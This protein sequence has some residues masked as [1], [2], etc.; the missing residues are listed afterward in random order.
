MNYGAEAPKPALSVCRIARLLAVA[1]W[2]AGDG[3][4]AGKVVEKVLFSI[5]RTNS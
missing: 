3:K 2:R 1:R 4:Q 5:H